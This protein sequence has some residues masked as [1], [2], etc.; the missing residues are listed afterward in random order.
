[1]VPQV[2]NHVRY[3]CHLIIYTT[4]VASAYNAVQNINGVWFKIKY[5]NMIETKDISWLYVLFNN[6]SWLLM[7]SRVKGA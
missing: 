5:T 7:V 1:M 4:G 3:T 6:L 2:V